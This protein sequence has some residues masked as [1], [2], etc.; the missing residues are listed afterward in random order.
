MATVARGMVVPR[1]LAVP[2]GAAR[3][4]GY[5]LVLPAVLYV[6]LL[7]GFPL[8]LGVWYS[9]TDVTVVR[10]GRFIGLKNFVD[11]VR[12]PTFRLALRNTLFIATVATAAK[13]TL[14]VALAFLLLGA[15]RGRSILRTLFVLPWTIPIARSTIAWTWM[16]D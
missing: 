15:F 2:R 8:V 4:K 9:L 13:I 6:L 16:F 5:L 12:D 7:L 11:V 14:S 3:Y 10:E 1:P